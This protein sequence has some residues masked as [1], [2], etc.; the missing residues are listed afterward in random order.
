M[1]TKAFVFPLEK[2]C[3]I[4]A[5]LIGSA[6][7]PGAP[8]TCYTLIPN[9]NLRSKTTALRNRSSASKDL[10]KLLA[11]LSSEFPWCVW[12]KCSFC[13]V[14]H[15]I[16]TISPSHDNTGKTS[17]GE[18]EPPGIPQEEWRR[19]STKELLLLSCG[20]GED[21]WESLGLQGDQSSQF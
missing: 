14:F 9:C 18:L 10:L 19:L 8:C 20:V 11:L 6:L 5:M 21:S 3:Y 4:L 1:K 16:W 7:G 17:R 15:L 2:N 12:L 13:S